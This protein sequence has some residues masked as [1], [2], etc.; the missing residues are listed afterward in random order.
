[1]AKYLILSGK[2]LSAKE[3]EEIGLIDKLITSDEMFELLEGGKLPELS[4][5]EHT[6]KWLAYSNLYKKNK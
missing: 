5:K 1:M 6:G 4:K 3:A 2:N